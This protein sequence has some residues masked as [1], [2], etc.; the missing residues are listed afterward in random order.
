MP[1]VERTLQIGLTACLLPKKPYSLPSEAIPRCLSDLCLG[2]KHNIGLLLMYNSA[3]QVYPC[4]LNSVQSAPQLLYFISFY[5]SI[6]FF[7]CCAPVQGKNWE[8]C[9]SILNQRGLQINIF[10]PLS[11][12]YKIHVFRC[13]LVKATVAFLLSLVILFPSNCLLNSGIYRRASFPF[14]YQK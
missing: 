3:S 7:Q 1:F 14:R 6:L 8:Q 4:W 9:S 13:R 12:F 5:D 2:I 11:T 10:L